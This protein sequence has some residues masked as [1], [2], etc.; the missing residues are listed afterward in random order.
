MDNASYYNALAIACRGSYAKLSRA[1]ARF[2]TWENA[3][4]NT[5]GAPDPRREDL[6]LQK[7]GIT[8]AL[9]D[10][11]VYP[12]PLK[13]APLPPFGLYYKGDLRYATPAVAI[14]GTRAATPEG[15]ATAWSF[16]RALAQA[17]IPIIS[18][19]ALGIDAEAHR[20]A[21]EAGG[22]MIAV[23]GTP[24]DSVYPRQ[25]HALAQEI[26]DAGG[27]LVSEFAIGHPY[28]ASNFLARNRI[29]S[30][31][32]TAV[33]IVEAPER[34]GTLATARFALEQNRDIFVVPG[35]IA[36]RNYKGSHALI[37][38]GATL[39]TSPEDILLQ[40]GVE[41]PSAETIFPALTDTE[42]RIIT[43][44]QNGGATAEQLLTATDLELS[45]LYQILASLTI[46][47]IIKELN[48]KYSLTNN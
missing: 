44:L 22:K 17:G 34:S 4:K 19:L 18:G 42:Q 37:K 38:A 23:L 16:A 46:K 12:S 39:V 14:V 21:L 36:S 32:S 27:A 11:P 30:G 1:L 31:L 20:G 10:D 25:H 47:C 5:H 45:E 8:L 26:L 3:W 43:A 6:I 29:V 48:G 35:S 40:L 13:E 33:L 41:R 7:N 24:L 28:H 15:K 2:G 9:S